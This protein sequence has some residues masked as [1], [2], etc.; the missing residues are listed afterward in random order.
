MCS[1]FEPI[2]NK[3]IQCK[4]IGK[5]ILFIKRPHM[6]I[7]CVHDIKTNGQNEGVVTLLLKHMLHITHMLHHAQLPIHS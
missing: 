3:K 1:L 6:T 2:F 5:T 4:F 7:F